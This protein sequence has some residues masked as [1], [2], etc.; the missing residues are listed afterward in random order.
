MIDRVLF[1]PIFTM[2]SCFARWGALISLCLTV[3]GCVGKEPALSLLELQVLDGFKQST[4][5]PV[6]DPP[7]VTGNRLSDAF[8]FV[9]HLPV[10][11]K[12]EWIKFNSVQLLNIARL[13][14]AASDDMDEWC[15][16]ATQVLPSNSICVTLSEPG[17]VLLQASSWADSSPIEV[18]ALGRLFDDWYCRGISK[19][20]DV[21]SFSNIWRSVE[22]F[23][24]G[25]ANWSANA[26]KEALPVL[27]KELKRVSSGHG[28]S[29]LVDRDVKL[30]CPG[31][32][33]QSLPGGFLWAVGSRGYL[34]SNRNAQDHEAP[35]MKAAQ[36][37]SWIRRQNN[38]GI[39]AK[40][41]PRIDDNER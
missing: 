32:D 15:N 25:G 4:G 41:N 20:L 22:G 30:A 18:I 24:E 1:V 29:V 17:L 23:R 28:I 6:F 39:L 8:I 38:N 2:A 13:R 36:F 26:H 12:D 27:L 5:I 11:K 33:Y 3:P 7:V 19:H 37:S 40:P 31:L 9:H 35:T 14:V 10:T 16:Y 21:A 34:I